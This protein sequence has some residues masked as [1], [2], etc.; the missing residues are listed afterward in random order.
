MGKGK[1]MRLE[2]KRL[3]MRPYA[4]SDLYDCYQLLSDKENMY[5]LNDITTE[6]L[7]EAK[8]SIDDAIEKMQNGEAQR[9]AVTLKE[10]GRLIG[11]VGYDITEINPLGRVGHIGWFILP[12]YQNKGYITEAATRVLEYAFLEDNCIR[13]TTGCYKENEPTQKVMA[14]LGFRQEAEKIKA[15]WH[16][17]KMKDRLEFAINRDEYRGECK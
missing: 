3:I 1:K 13:I 12:E 17:G 9:F 14:K 5:Y 7:E 10:N 2:S 4:V 8:L 11:G 15:Q 6:S 16:D